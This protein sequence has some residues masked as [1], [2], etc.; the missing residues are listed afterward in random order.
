MSKRFQSH[1]HNDYISDKKFIIFLSVTIELAY[2]TQRLSQF[3]KKKCAPVLLATLVIDAA[4]ECRYA[5]ISQPSQT[6]LLSITVTSGTT[7]PVTTPI[8]AKYSIE[9]TVVYQGC[10]TRF[11]GKPLKDDYRPCLASCPQGYTATG[12]LV[13]Y[14]ILMH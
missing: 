4:C 1:L 3:S 6:H 5:S 11:P 12:V 14:K 9:T 2:D 10:I 8:S 13:D 7:T